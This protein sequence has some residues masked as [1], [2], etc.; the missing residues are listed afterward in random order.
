MG[1]TQDHYRGEAGHRYHWDKRG[2]P[3]RAYLW[4]ARLRAAKF[5]G[6]VRADDIVLEYGVGAGWNLALLSCRKRLGHDVAPF[7]ASVLAA[8]GIEYVADT[9]TLEGGAMDLVICHHTGAHAGARNGAGGDRRLLRP[10]GKL[11]LSVPYEKERVYRRFRPEEP[12][13][14]LYSWNVQRWEIW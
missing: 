9:G 3:D 8:R 1:E 13:H 4:V 5:S 6:Q 12:N 7:L 14:H 10:G 2:I 11:W